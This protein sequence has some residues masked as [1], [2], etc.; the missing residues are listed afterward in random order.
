MP[1]SSYVR[2]LRARVGTGL[3]MLPGVA[4]L[5]RDEEGRILLHL[6]TD[7]NRWSL[8][9]GGLEPG[10][11]PARAVIREVREETGLLVVPERIAGVFG[12]AAF[13]HTYPNGDVV[14]P[15][16]ILFECR[17]EGGTLGG[18]DGETQE[19]RYFPPA[20]LPRLVQPYPAAL[21]HAVLDGGTCFEWDPAWLEE[22]ASAPAGSDDGEE[23]P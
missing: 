6:R 18:M 22:V 9:A 8:P 13:R 17:V 10:E 15:T 4:A 21:F 1:I 2:D 7:D 16:V 23:T 12:G 11:P 3:L 20:E 14:E 5:I 19:I